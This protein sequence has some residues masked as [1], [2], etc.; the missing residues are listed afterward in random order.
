[1]SLTI[2]VSTSV[3]IAFGLV[4]SDVETSP[5]TCVFKSIDCIVTSLYIFLVTWFVRQ[6]LNFEEKNVC[7]FNRKATFVC[8]VWLFL[9]FVF[10]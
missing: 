1:M 3:N 7:F 4:G 8:Y 2:R 10:R 9:V 6:G 5:V